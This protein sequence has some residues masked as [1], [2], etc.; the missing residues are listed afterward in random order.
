MAAMTDPPPDRPPLLRVE[1]LNLTFP[2]VQ[3][4]AD[5][6]W[7]IRPGEVHVLVGENGAGKSSLVKVIC[8]VYRTERGTMQLDGTAYDPVTPR[9]AIEAGIRVVHQELQYLPS[10]S[11]A[12]NLTIESPP[13]RF[14]LVD[15][16]VMHARARDLLAQVGLAV[17]TT[18]RAE[19]L[20]IAQLQLLEIAKALAS[21][22]RL[23]ILDEPTATLTPTEVASLFAIVRGL[24]DEGVAVLYISHHLEEI[25]EIGD[26]VTVMRNGAVAATLPV[27]DTTVPQLVRLM[28]GRD[29]HHEDLAPAPVREG[30]E[31]L[32]IE[33]LRYHGN[34][35]AVD[36]ELAEGEILGIAGL[37]G[38]GR[39]ETVRALFGADRRDGGRIWLRGEEVTI[40][41][42]ADAVRAGI[43]L[44]TEDRKG[45]GLM[46]SMS[47]AA[48]VTVTD[49]R[50]V[51]HRALLDRS[52]E[53]VAADRYR[54]ELG[55]RTPSVDTAVGSLSGGNQQKY[56]LAKWLF[57][58]ADVLVLDEPTRGVDVGAKFEIYA[59]LRSLAA[60]GHGLIVVS[61]D[62]PE[63]MLLCHRIAVVS[64]GRISG[65]LTRE[66][67]DQESILTLAYQASSPDVSDSE[68]AS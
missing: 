21:R 60:R 50:A 15:R 9:D 67:F 57:R 5:V 27:P 36:L 18:T 56:V 11:V 29:L 25:A 16:R 55:I 2:G 61:S 1:H 51:S 3:A 8:G 44:L 46:L 66:E 62:L 40:T 64:R 45:E 17:P 59:L 13:S 68:V 6:S 23:I 47:G 22:S 63:L 7:E 20:G 53:R 38:S 39:T 19:Q 42:P 10:L 52:A 24:C 14:G 30:T 35:H 34:P 58:G 26:R 32:R 37:M 48:N 49:L 31:L 4:L 33:G 65:E 12:E 54:D 41:N 43:C 28:V